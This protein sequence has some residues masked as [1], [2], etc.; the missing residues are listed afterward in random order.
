VGPVPYTVGNSDHE[1]EDRQLP[2]SA[3]LLVATRHVQLAVRG[4]TG[5]DFA[6][7]AIIED[8]E[9]ARHSAIYTDLSKLGAGVQPIP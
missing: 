3:G 8:L 7:I 2:V 4:V 9:A 5:V 6:A 1:E